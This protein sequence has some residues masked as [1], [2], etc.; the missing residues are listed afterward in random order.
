MI[1]K[2]IIE[3]RDSPEKVSGLRLVPLG[4]SDRH[5]DTVEPVKIS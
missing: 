4:K 1:K 5:T 2:T 3:A